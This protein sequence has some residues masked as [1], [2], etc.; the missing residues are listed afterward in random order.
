MGCAGGIVFLKYII[1]EEK[2][3][4]VYEGF[5]YNCMTMAFKFACDS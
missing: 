5:V 3:I 2:Q 1:H 4:L